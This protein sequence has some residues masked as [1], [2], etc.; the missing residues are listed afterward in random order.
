MSSTYVRARLPLVRTPAACTSRVSVT[1]SRG[2]GEKARSEAV[3]AVGR[4]AGYLCW[5]EPARFPFLSSFILPPNPTSGEPRALTPYLC[6]KKKVLEGFPNQFKT[7]P[8]RAKRCLAHLLSLDGT[9]G[10]NFHRNVVCLTYLYHN[11][12]QKMRQTHPNR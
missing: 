8:R 12:P 5:Q 2:C 3:T 11:P 10:L 7:K 6:P 1:G 4:K 9:S